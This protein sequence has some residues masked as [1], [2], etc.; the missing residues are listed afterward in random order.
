[1]KNKDVDFYKG[2]PQGAENKKENYVDSIMLDHP[3]FWFED[4]WGMKMHFHYGQDGLSQSLT[5][6]QFNV[7]QQLIKQ[8]VIKLIFS[9]MMSSVIKFL[10]Y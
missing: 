8:G 7:C 3:E 6:M 4:P 1:M 2:L 5:L 10:T 9:L